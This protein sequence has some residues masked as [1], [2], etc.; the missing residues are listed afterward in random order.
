MISG[1]YRIRDI[2]L[3]LAHCAKSDSVDVRSVVGRWADRKIS[4]SGG[5]RWSANLG[6]M[7]DI[8]V[9]SVYELTIYREGSIVTAY[10]LLQCLAYAESL[11][12]FSPC[13]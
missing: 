6:R 2:G 5:T 13:H 7:S 9:E 4:M 1:A 11:I 12:Q 8:E 10:N 3:V